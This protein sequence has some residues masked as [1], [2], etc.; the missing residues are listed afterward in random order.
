MLARAVDN[1][2]SGWIVGADGNRHPVSQHDANSKAS[3]FA[4]QMGKD[5]KSIVCFDFEEPSRQNFGDD[6]IHFDMIFL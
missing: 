1:A 3:H 4:R 6:S 2:A 5:I